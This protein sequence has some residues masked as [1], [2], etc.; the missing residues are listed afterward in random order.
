M[1]AGVFPCRTKKDRTPEEDDMLDMMRH[2][3]E[4]WFHTEEQMQF[5]NHWIRECTSKHAG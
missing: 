2:G 4:H 5:L 3:G 1:K